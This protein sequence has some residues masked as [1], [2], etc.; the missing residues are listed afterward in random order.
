M[1]H[2]LEDRSKEINR[3]TMWGVVVNLLL[4]IA[5]IIGGFFGHSQALIA[6]GIHSLS[7]LASDGMVLYASKHAG[8][9]ADED[10]PYG[11]GRFETLATVILGAFL[12]L[13]S[14]GIAYDAFNRLVTR[15]AIE[16][17]HTY[18]LVIALASVM[19]KEGLYH[20]TRNVGLAINSKML[21]ANAW[22]HRS[23]AIS[24]I[25]VLGGIIGAQM[26]VPSLDIIAAI[27]V[28]LMIGKIGYD[29]GYQGLLELVDTAL[30]PETVERIKEKILSHEDVR[31]VHML[32]TRQMGHTA[33]V[34]VHIM[35]SP[36]LSVSEGHHISEKVERALIDNFDSIND[37]TVHIDPENDEEESRSSQL[38]LRSEL[39]IA[40]NQAWS[41]IPELKAIDDITLHYL[42]GEIMVE[43][44]LP[45]TI[46]ASLEDS[47]G[48]KQKFKLASLGVEHV[49]EAVLKFH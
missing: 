8:N 23:D 7:D 10:H 22:H 32:R 42:D 43:A 13:V 38:P 18:T 3:V 17:P 2:S 35:V 37:V 33:L 5:K 46:L 45:L 49:G 48:L 12:I 4:S 39:I 40:L 9:E 28:S 29:L 47:E 34:D 27:V 14:I 20:F 6:D 36:K 31:A 15:E 26:G 1:A 44:T 11:H 16:I 19:S 24:S 25:V 30:D 21:I 41:K